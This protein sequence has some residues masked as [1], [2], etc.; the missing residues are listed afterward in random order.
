METC[1][2]SSFIGKRAGSKQASESRSSA[3]LLQ[4]QQFPFALYP[5]LELTMLTGIGLSKSCS[6]RGNSS[7][8]FYY[9][10]NKYLNRN[11]VISFKLFNIS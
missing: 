6:C 11:K 5:G 7:Y 2:Y 9:K 4:V 1:E 3:T 8:Q 10:L